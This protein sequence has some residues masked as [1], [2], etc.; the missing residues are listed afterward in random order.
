MGSISVSIFNTLLH[1]EPLLS[2]VE[3]HNLKQ[4]FVRAIIVQSVSW[5]PQH[6]L[7]DTLVVSIQIPVDSDDILVASGHVFTPFYSIY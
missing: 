2:K 1:K 7:E 4:Y 3:K 6:W 5:T